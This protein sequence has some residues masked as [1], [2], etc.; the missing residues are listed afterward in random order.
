MP[1]KETCR[2]VTDLARHLGIEWPHNVLRLWLT[3]CRIA[4]IINANEVALERGI[5]RTSSSG[6]IANWP[7]K[8]RSVRGLPLY[9]RPNEC[10][11][12]RVFTCHCRVTG[13]VERLRLR[14]GLA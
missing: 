12:C 1:S 10:T 8:N 6:T 11:R 2:K 4:K 7:P 13:E 5:R 14:A 9:Q 3:C